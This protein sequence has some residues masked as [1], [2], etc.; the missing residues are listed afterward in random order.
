MVDER[1]DDRARAAQ[2]QVRPDEELDRAGRAEAVDEVLRQRAI[3]L[4]RAPGA[5]QRRAVAA[6]VHDVGVEAVLVRVVAEPAVARAERPALRT[7]EVGDE[8]RRHARVRLAELAG[9]RVEQH[10]ERIGAPAP[11]VAVGRH[12]RRIGSQVTKSVPACGQL[13]PVLEAPV[14]R[15]ARRRPSAARRAAAPRAPPRRGRAARSALPRAP[16]PAPS[17]RAAPRL[18]SAR[19]RPSW[20]K[21]YASHMRPVSRARRAPRPTPGG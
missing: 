5:A 16:R 17:R 18:P 4:G 21:G 14:P 8:D 6:R 13:H 15:A 3:D 9:H 19:G 1:H 12:G 10:D 7:A 20:P 2:V 11:P